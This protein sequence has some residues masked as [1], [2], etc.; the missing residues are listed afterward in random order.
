MSRVDQRLLHL[1]CMQEISA[2]LL[3]DAGAFA[4]SKFGAVVPVLSGSLVEGQS[5]TDLPPAAAA[6]TYSVM[7]N[8][9]ATHGAPT[10]LNVL[11]SALYARATGIPE[12]RITARTHPLP[13]TQYQQAY[14]QGNYGFN[15]AGKVLNGFVLCTPQKPCILDSVPFLQSL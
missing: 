9:S 7:H 11:N 3:N 1:R 13:F 10:W 12:A 4:A 14:V 6:A 8:T 15:V 2:Y 5:P